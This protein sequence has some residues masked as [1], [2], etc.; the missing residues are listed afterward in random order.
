MH[1]VLKGISTAF[2]QNSDFFLLAQ[3]ATATYIA[4]FIQCMPWIIKTFMILNDLIIDS[5]LKLRKSER[6][7]RPL[8]EWSPW[9]PTAMGVSYVRSERN[10][11]Y[12]KLCANK[13]IAF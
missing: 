4:Y 1:D 9:K 11:N 10:I 13:N 3:H 6:E 2:Q 5:C 8:R 7:T 12:V